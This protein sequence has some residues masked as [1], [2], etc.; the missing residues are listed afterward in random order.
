VDRGLLDKVLL[1][2]MQAILE[3]LKIKAAVAV[4]ELVVQGK[5]L[6]KAE[7]EAFP[8]KTL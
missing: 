1:E 3:L 5:R 4:V 6:L 2:E 8:F 7:A